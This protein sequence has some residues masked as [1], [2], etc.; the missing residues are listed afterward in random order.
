MKKSCRVILK[1]QT[2]KKLKTFKRGKLQKKIDNFNPN[3]AQKPFL[4]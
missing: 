4:S 1:L 2:K 3:I